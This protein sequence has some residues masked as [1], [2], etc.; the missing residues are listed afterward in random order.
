M[1]VLQCPIFINS[2]HSNIPKALHLHK[3]T[4]TVMCKEKP[5]LLFLHYAISLLICVVA[6]RCY[7]YFAASLKFYSTQHVL[8]SEI[9]GLWYDYLTWGVFSSVVLLVWFMTSYLNK[10][11]ANVALHTL[12]LA[13]LFC[14]ISLL[15]VFIDRSVPFD[16]EFFTRDAAEQ[17]VTIKSYAG[18]GIL[19][20]LPFILITILY[21]GAYRLFLS[22]IQFNR[23]TKKAL[24][25]AI[26]APLF[27]IKFIVPSSSG[28][29][30]TGQYYLACN[31]ASYWTTDAIKYFSDMRNHR[32]M[33]AEEMQEEFAYFQANRPFKFTDKNYPLM[34]ENRDADVLSPFFNPGKE[35]PNIVLVVVESLSRT[36]SGRNAPLTSF[37]PFLDELSKRSLCWDNH[38]SN[39]TATFGVFPATLASLPFGNR[40]FSNNSIMPDHESLISILKQNGYYSYFMVGYPL[41]Y[42]NMGGFIRMQKTDFILRNYGRK[43]KMMAEGEGGW[44]MGYPDDALFNRSFEVLDSLKKKPYLNVYMTASTHSPFLFDAQPRYLKLFDKKLKN[45]P[46]NKETKLSLHKNRQVMSC[47]M[48]ADDALRDFFRK[49][50]RRPEYKNTIFIVTGDHHHGSVPANND[51]DDYRV[52]FMIYSPMLKKPL[53]FESINCHNNITPT[54]LG[55]LAKQYNLQHI[56]KRVHWMN[57]MMDT[58]TKFRNIHQISFMTYS[59]VMESYMFKNYFMRENR[60]FRINPDMSEVECTNPA[61]K[62]KINHLRDNFIAVNNWVY[63][64]NHILPDNTMQK[65]RVLLGNI[66]I[67]QERDFV[68]PVDFSAFTKNIAV[69]PMYKHLYVEADFDC[70]TSEKDSINVPEFCF[71]LASRPSA[72]TTKELFWTNKDMHYMS[73]ARFLPNQWN[74]LTVHDVI[75]IEEYLKN[76]N[77]EL[78]TGFNAVTK[79]GMKVKNFRMKLY[80][81]K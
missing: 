67:P 21:F 61:M 55:F 39:A 12:N 38:L 76:N 52:P 68:T 4:I 19:A 26:I 18:N 2:F 49:Y 69:P 40:G 65:N 25:V 41:D 53:R 13:F 56:P 54:L 24:W 10:R 8:L 5:K 17:I 44:S 23:V 62:Q 80:G 66:Y 59:R 7:E 50:S 58:A 73:G 43:Y 71:M 37:T 16:H 32:K 9:H 35:R 75:G 6:V 78:C 33:S 36:F 31:K 74:S 34:H 45:L 57:G 15:Y 27:L 48:F 63:E 51:I 72:E 77:L 28:F 60:L 14:C 1:I 22:R 47:V 42:D 46:L 20:F 11:V 81:M 70:F 64:N 3:K 30:Q 29:G 79:V